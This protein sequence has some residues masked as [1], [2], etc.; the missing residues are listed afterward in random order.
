MSDEINEEEMQRLNG[1]EAESSNERAPTRSGG[2]LWGR[3]KEKT[4]KVNKMKNIVNVFQSNTRSFLGV[5]SSS[6]SHQPTADTT[7]NN[8]NERTF[9]VLSSNFLFGGKIKDGKI[10]EY[11]DQIDNETS[12]EAGSFLY[13]KH[14]N[15]PIDEGIE[16]LGGLV[17]RK[18]NQVLVATGITKE[19]E[20]NPDDDRVRSLYHIYLKN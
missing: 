1:N 15:R 17:K 10:Q 11:L 16:G 8:W 4:V 19:P 9:K 20:T 5:D 13:Y 12:A 2:E 6:T 7:L 18:I 14:T 3:A